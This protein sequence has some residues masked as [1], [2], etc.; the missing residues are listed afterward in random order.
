[1]THLGLCLSSLGRHADALKLHEEALAGRRQILTPDHVDTRW[2]MWVV[3]DSL[4]KLN[5]GAEAIA[6]IDECLTRSTGDSDLWL[7]LD[8]VS[9]RIRHFQSTNDPPRCRTT[10]EM[11][12]NRNYSDA[13][14]LY[15]A[16][17]FRA[18]TSAVLKID[19]KT[20]AADATR[21]ATEEADRAMAWLRK[22]VAAGFK[23]AGK[24]TKDTN[25]DALR[26][27]ED[28]KK[29]LAELEGTKK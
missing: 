10:A 4:V 12:E 3:A 1:V 11:W 19:P 22:A 8:A 29:L 18:V 2:S 5:R 23:D 26:A 27:R 17:C 24:M 20:P 7:V 28:F 15:N 14:S 21:L 6:L 16:A 25:L 13:D 9:L